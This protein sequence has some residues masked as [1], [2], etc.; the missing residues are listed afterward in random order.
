MSNRHYTELR[1]NVYTC[2]KCKGMTVTVDIDEG[3]TPMFLNCRASG[4]E[5]DCDGMAVSAM[6]PKGPRPPHVPAPAWE[7][8]KPTGKDY[9]RLSPA[10]KEHVDAGGL[11]IR[12]RMI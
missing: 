9:A 1:E 6:Y 12:K 11:D 5:G 8:F 3:V 4:R 2:P 10:M 7:W